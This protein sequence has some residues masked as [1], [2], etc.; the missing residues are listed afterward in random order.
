MYQ[1]R[2]EHTLN[3]CLFVFIFRNIPKTWPST[4]GRCS[5]ATQARGQRLWPPT[6]S[7]TTLLCTFRMWWRSSVLQAFHLQHAWVRSLVL[8]SSLRHPKGPSAG[9][10]LSGGPRGPLVPPAQHQHA[11]SWRRKFHTRA[12]WL[13]PSRMPSKTWWDQCLYLMNCAWKPRGKICTR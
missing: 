10:R 13:V 2:Q 8:I 12:W 1:K 6:S 9:P 7:I 4:T 5:M 11:S 3:Y